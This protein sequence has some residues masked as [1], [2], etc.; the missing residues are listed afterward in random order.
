MSGADCAEPPG[1]QYYC[2]SCFQKIRRD[3]KVCSNCQ[4]DIAGWLNVRSY[5]ERL[6]HALKHPNSEARMGSII[7]LGNLRVTRAAL[8]LAACALAFPADDVQ[9]LEI[10]RALAKMPT[11]REKEAALSALSS[12]PSRIIRQ[13]A[14]RQLGV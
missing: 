12:H 8:P 6:I 4:V 3:D 13:E 7:A 11:G 9:N 5:E 14:L 10:L 2:P 1:P